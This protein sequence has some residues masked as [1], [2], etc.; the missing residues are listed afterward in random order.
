[1]RSTIPSDAVLPEVETFSPIGSDLARNPSI[2]PVS[3]PLQVAPQL[4]AP[5]MDAPIPAAAQPQPQPVVQVSPPAQAAVRPE[6]QIVPPQLPVAIGKGGYTLAVPG[7]EN[8]VAPFEPSAVSMNKRTHTGPVVA[9]VGDEEQ[10]R[11]WKQFLSSSVGLSALA[12]VAVL[13]AFA[14][15]VIT[16]GSNGSDQLAAKAPATE[17]P[18]ASVVARSTN[19]NQDEKNTLVPRR[20]KV[21]RFNVSNAKKAAS[22]PKTVIDLTKKADNASGTLTNQLTGLSG[23]KVQE[24]ASLGI[25]IPR[26]KPPV[27]PK[28]FSAHHNSSGSIFKELASLRDGTRLKPVT[29]VHM[30]DS[31]IASDAFTRGIRNGLQAE[32][33][34]AGR[35]AILPAKAFKWTRADGVKMSTSGTWSSAS[36]LTTKTGPYGLSGVRVWSSSSNAKMNLAA[37]GQG[38][39]WAEVTVLTGPKQGKV[40]ISAGGQSKTVN[41]AA[42]TRGSKVVRVKAYSKTASVSPAGGGRT[43]VLNWATGREEAGVRYVNFGI[44]SAT[45]HLQKRWDKNLI[46]NDIKHLNPDLVVWGYGTNEGFNSNLDMKAYRNQVSSIYNTVSA[47]APKADWLFLGPASGLSRRGKA[48]GHCN[49]YRI[50]LKLGAVRSTLQDFAAENGRH[51]WDW[52]AAMGGDC[53]I[54]KWARSSPKLALSDRVHLNSAGYQK[55][56]DALVAH[57]KKLVDK[58]QVV[59]AVSSE[60]IGQ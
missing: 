58:P 55:S 35:G 46:A 39:D 29:I 21:E 52:N 7:A 27:P 5:S 48:A 47:A 38:F 34:N 44:V 14:H 59:A 30:G 8:M 36:S 2:P 22:A 33:G 37:T 49:G 50:P 15:Q 54:D 6:P 23:D 42:P 53:A 9:A 60:E 13:A 3:A 19:A 17:Q 31:H 56:A 18:T 4:I 1:M 51:F 10:K 25:A 40:K 20:V 12:T 24:F 41:A 11:S 32:Y 57:I 26:E 16:P 43:T 28:R 45:A